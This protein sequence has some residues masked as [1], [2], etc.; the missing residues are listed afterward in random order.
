MLEYVTKQLIAFLLSL[1]F[2]S[3]ISPILPTPIPKPSYYFYQINKQDNL[4]VIP[5]FDNPKDSVDL[6]KENKCKYA[7]NGGLYQ[8]N[9]KPLGLFIH[10]NKVINKKINSNIFNGYL[11]LDQNNTLNIGQNTIENP[12][13]IVQTGPYFNLNSPQIDYNDKTARRHVIAKDSTN[14]FYIFSIFTSESTVS[15]PTLNQI[16]DFFQKPEIQKISDFKEILTLD[17]GSASV[18]YSPTDSLHE[19][20]FI[21]SLLCW[22]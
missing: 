11:Y 2:S 3:D 20:T 14:N 6:I 17:G 5:N 13:Y 10:D 8:E 21:G 16:P 9:K 4:V 7:I 15:G 1:F 12:K 22:K 18:F 19:S